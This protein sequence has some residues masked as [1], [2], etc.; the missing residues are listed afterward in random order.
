MDIF[1]RIA[2]YYDKIIPN[3]NIYDI[4]PYMDIKPS[5]LILDF[6]G[7]TGRVGAKLLN[8]AN[9][10]LILD[11]SFSMLREARKKTHSLLLLNSDGLKLAVRNNSI[12][13]IFL[14]DTFHHLQNHKQALKECFRVLKNDGVLYI[15]EYDKHYFWNKLLILFEKILR[16]K[17]TFFSLGR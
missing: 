13:V 6:G 15:R 3:F 11:F 1:S 7:G 12:P 10:C 16:F 9:E 8:V 2:R 4:L 14:N 17:S 5:A